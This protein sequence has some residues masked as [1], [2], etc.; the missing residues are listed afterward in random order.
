MNSSS[1]ES[2]P[3]NL[4]KFENIRENIGFTIICWLLGTKEIRERLFVNYSRMIL[5]VINCSMSL[6]HTRAVWE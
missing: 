6:T 4:I 1:S 2:L 5:Y 3:E